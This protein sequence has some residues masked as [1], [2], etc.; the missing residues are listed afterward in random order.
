KQYFDTVNHDKLM[1]HLEEHIKD[2][3]IL[4]L[5]RKFLR[6]GVSIN[7][8]IV[9]TEIGVPQGGNI[10]PILS[11]LF[12]DQ[13]DKELE[14]RGHQFVRYADD[15]NIYVKSRKAGERVMKSATTFLEEKLKLTVNREKSEIGS[16]TKR[17]FL[18]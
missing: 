4:T 11:N 9:P 7:G 10:S 14:K 16:P 13:F 12:L 3:I 2:K 8:T 18:G 6:S 5:I 17:K 15:C 1:F